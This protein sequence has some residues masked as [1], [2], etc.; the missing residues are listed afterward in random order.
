[1]QSLLYKIL[2]IKCLSSSPIF[3]LFASF[4]HPR[5]SF[6]SSTSYSRSSNILQWVVGCHWALMLHGQFSVFSMLKSRIILGW[7]FFDTA[8]RESFQCRQT[9]PFLGL[10]FTKIIYFVLF[11]VFPYMEGTSVKLKYFC[12]LFRQLVKSNR[13]LSLLWIQ[14]LISSLLLISIKELALSFPSA[15][16]RTSSNLSNYIYMRSVA[17]SYL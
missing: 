10:Q 12:K 17:S 1:M 8:S 9:T 15:G 6:H 11:L 4:Y 7:N 14:N 3:Y 13:C 16:A 5:I 2:K